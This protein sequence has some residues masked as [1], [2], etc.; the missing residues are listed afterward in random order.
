MPHTALHE[1]NRR[2]WN[3][4]TR[5]RADSLAAHSAFFGSGG[6]TLH[7][8]ELEL[9]SDVH[10]A[11]LA[12]LQCNDGRDTLSLARLGARVSGVDISDTAIEVAR[13]LASA[14]GIPATFE[15]ADVYDWLDAT[16]TAGRQFDIVF[17]SYGFIFWLSDIER[18]AHGIRRILRPGGRFVMVELHPIAQTFER[19]WTHVY[20]YFTRG[21]VYSW[22]HSLGAGEQSASDRPT[23]S[24]TGVVTPDNP[25]RTHEFWWSLSDVLTALL[26]AGLRLSAF[27]EY[28]YL[29]GSWH[30]ETLRSEADGRQYPPAGVPGIPL[31][32]G[33]RA[34]V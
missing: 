8:E 1:Q 17:S 23:L 22:E 19:D 16:Q 20:P 24:A 10:G 5:Q 7:P 34:E 32:Y 11:E 4:T 9:L 6:S 2:V 28:P 31:M 30:F 15:R 12:H 18:W 26:A 21:L 25:Q 13:R 33:V 29:Y 3:A 14:T 27:R